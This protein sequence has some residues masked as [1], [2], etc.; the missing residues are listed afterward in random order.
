MQDNYSLLLF[1]YVY[2]FVN[3]NYYSFPT[4]ISAALTA[5]LLPFPCSNSLGLFHWPT[6]PKPKKRILTKEKSIFGWEGCVAQWNPPGPS[7]LGEV[8]CS[9]G[10]TPSGRPKQHITESKCTCCGLVCDSRKL[11]REFSVRDEG[12]WLFVNTPVWYTRHLIWSLQR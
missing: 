9:Q 11:A 10:M 2:I 6:Q 4:C 12:L 1:V 3:F 8:S 7:R 5:F